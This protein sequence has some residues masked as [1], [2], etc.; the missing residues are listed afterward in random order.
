MKS[1]LPFLK[2][3][4]IFRDRVREGDRGNINQLPLTHPLLE[5]GGDLAHDARLCPDRESSLRPLDSQAGTQPSEPH[6]P[7][8]IHLF[9]HVYSVIT[10]KSFPKSQ[11]LIPVFLF[12]SFSFRMSVYA[13]PG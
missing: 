10:K 4:L 12:P 8:P 7:G 3:L 13:R 2:I 9:Y 6:Q 1:N 5:V 11:K